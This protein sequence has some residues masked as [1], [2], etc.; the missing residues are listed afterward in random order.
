M[1][2]RIKFNA[3]P[4]PAFRFYADPRI[5]LLIKVMR[6]CDHCEPPRLLYE[7]L[8]PTGHHGSISEL[9]KLLNF[10]F[11]ADP[12]PA[13]HSNADLDQTLKDIAYPCGSGFA[14]L[15]STGSQLN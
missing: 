14:T 9:L 3:D 2:I 7:R 10:E 5:L 15:L 4:D 6:I 1:R 13:F 11:S 8:Q 12:D